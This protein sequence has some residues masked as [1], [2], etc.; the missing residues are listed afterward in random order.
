MFF[1]AHLFAGLIIGC[2]SGNYLVAL[3]G[4]L[5]LDL[6][7]LWVYAKH[8]I[9]FKP[10]KLWKAIINPKDPYGNQRNLLHRYGLLL[11]G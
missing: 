4:A 5:F 10:K 6:D 8:G 9:L 11:G 1:F 7:H 2:L 3:I